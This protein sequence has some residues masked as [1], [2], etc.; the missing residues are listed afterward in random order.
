VPLREMSRH[1]HDIR[2]AYACAWSSI[3]YCTVYVPDDAPTPLVYALYAHELAH[4]NGW[5]HPQEWPL[6]KPN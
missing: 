4:C 5:R 1:C 2:H 6:A 3:D